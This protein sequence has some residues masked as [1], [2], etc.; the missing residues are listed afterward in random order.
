ME[1]LIE[2]ILF[3]TALTLS[4][5]FCLGAILWTLNIIDPTKFTKVINPLPYNI[6]IYL[7]ILLWGLL[8]I[9]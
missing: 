3:V 5:K 4:L 6:M 8:Y 9:M 1:K 7:A 2:F